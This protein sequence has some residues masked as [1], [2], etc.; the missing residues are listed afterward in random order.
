MT[1]ARPKYVGNSVKRREDPRLLRGRGRYVADIKLPGM[2]YM[3]LVR[4]PVAHAR[5]TG[6]DTSR[7]LAQ[8]GVLAAISYDDIRGEVKPLPLAE[9][10]EL[11]GDIDVPA[12]DVTAQ[13]SRGIGPIACIDLM[14]GSTVVLQTVLADRKVRYVGEPV[15]A[16]VATDPYLAEDALELVDVDYEPL[17]PVVDLLAAAA[18]GAPLLYEELGTNVFTTVRQEVGDVDAAFA[19]A[20]RTY[21]R[22]FRIH[23]YAPV[24][25]ET[26]GVVADAD[27]V[28]RR[29]TLYSSTQF[30]HLARGFLAGALSMPESRIRVVAPDVGGGFGAK[31]EFYPEEVLAPL[32]SLQLGRPVKWIEDRRE[33]MIAST[34]AREQIHEIEAAVDVDGNVTA[35]RARSHTNNGAAPS[36]LAITPTSIFSAMLRG[37]YRIPHCRVEAKAVFTNKT[38]LAVY[39]GAGHPQ[40]AFCM[41]RMMDI[42]A[43]DLGVD[44]AEF[45]R[46][47]M[48]TSAELPSDR[49]TEIVLAGKVVYDSGD[50]PRCL[51]MALE[52][53]DYEGFLREQEPA[54][55][56]G[57]YLGLGI[58]AYVEET[59]I[60][61]YE[62]ATVRVDGTGKV[63]VIT[64]SC[65]QGQGHV[66]AFSQ[67][68]AD[69]FDIDL[70]DVTV[71]YGDTD[72]VADGV[73]TF[74]SRSGAIGGAAARQ[75]AAKVRL[76][77][78][79][80]AS[81]ILEVDTTDLEWAGGAASVKGVPDRRLTLGELA[82]RATA[83]NTD[84]PEDMSFNL[85]ETHHHQA[86]GIAFGNATHIAVVEVDV[87]TGKIDILRY[88]V[89]HDCGTVINPLIVDGQV[90]G[91]VV[92]GLG[93]I[94]LEELVYDAE[95]QPLSTSFADYLLPTAAEVPHIVT[96]HLEIP[97]PLNPYGMKGA[98]EG[99]AVG[100]PGAIVNAIDDALAP[101]GVTLTTD[102]P[103][104]PSRVLE[105][106]D[107]ARN[108]R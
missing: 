10:G 45:R 30:P 103:Y 105:L 27:P 46:R 72:V 78:M 23:R 83:W 87:R 107:A 51:D 53:M 42:I 37:P 70:D 95:G 55:A 6:I 94:L 84:L 86:P 60:G 77:A 25:I 5:I 26:R 36:T 14:P 43:R 48:L 73:G 17:E 41:E 13:Q 19:A 63:T 100:S 57:R 102:G 101:L 7:A 108:G 31:C 89:V 106:I 76:K 39:R 40:A 93:G 9:R 56:Q 33:H 18:D 58:C 71:L 62:S 50:Y 65:P 88:G 59:A 2:V 104:S 79:Q 16:V 20:D 49:G 47:N 85:D 97:T 66:T 96:E 61:P 80:L 92:Q 22:T 52:L 90:H 38:P 8:R 15:V 91:G 1:A 34:H 11:I 44:R 54:R 32:L 64:G 82:T 98:G 99:G 4:S 35:V 74:A 81:H 21:A 69:E 75:A 3:A 28:D 12:E 29:V 67:L 24:P 68:V